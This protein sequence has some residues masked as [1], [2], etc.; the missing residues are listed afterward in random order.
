M[1]EPDQFGQ[2]HP[3]ETKD[4]IQAK[5]EELEEELGNIE[6]KDAYEQAKKKC[7]DQLTDDVKLGFLRCEVFNADLAAE[8]LVNYW[9]KRMFFFGSEKA[10]LPL[11][12]AGMFAG[13]DEGLALGFATLLP[14]IKGPG[15]RAVVLA[16]P[17]KNDSS[18]ATRIQMAQQLWYTVHAA[19][20]DEETQKNGLI[21]LACPRNAKFKQFDS[22]LLKLNM[23]SMKGALPVRISCISICHPPSFFRLIWPVAKLIMGDRVRQRVKVMGG[24]NESVMKQC[25][26][27][28][29]PKECVPELIGGTLKVDHL[30]WLEAR[31][32]AGK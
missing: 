12:Q 1:S 20:E 4:M 17:S 10:F 18:K 29:L 11:T 28:G 8:R 26:S 16:D 7:P 31:K 15:G 5:L 25:E 9:E 24:S 19:L 23:G 32:K 2:S 3:T 14:G 13:N 27:I 30:A 22:K 6:T 21:I